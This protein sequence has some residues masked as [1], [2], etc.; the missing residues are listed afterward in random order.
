[1]RNVRFRKKEDILSHLRHHKSSCLTVEDYCREHSIAVSTF[2]NW[3]KKYSAKL[4]QQSDSV[5]FVPVSVT[6]PEATGY[7]IVYSNLTIRV[8][9]GIKQSALRELFTVLLEQR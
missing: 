9:S 5:A 2:F 3:R 4:T 7:E 1:M 8:P 6:P